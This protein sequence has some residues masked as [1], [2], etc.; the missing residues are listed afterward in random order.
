MADQLT[1]MNSAAAVSPPN[2]SKERAIAFVTETAGLANIEPKSCVTQRVEP[3]DQPLELHLRLWPESRTTVSQISNV[4]ATSD[5]ESRAATSRYLEQEAQHVF[6]HLASAKH[7]EGLIAQN[8]TNCYVDFADGAALAVN[9]V[10]ARWRE[11]CTQCGATGKVRCH[12]GQ[13]MYGRCSVTCSSCSGNGKLKCHSCTGG[14]VTIYVSVQRSDGSWGQESRWENC[15]NCGGTTWSQSCGACSGSGHVSCPSCGGSGT[16]TCSGCSGHKYQYFEMVTR[17]VMCLKREVIP[18][19]DAPKR[20]VDALRTLAPTYV[21]RQSAVE[22]AL[23]ARER[24]EVRRRFSVIIKSLSFDVLLGGLPFGFEAIG[25]DQR[26]ANSP[27]FMDTL[28][29]PRM[30]DIE[31]A[32]EQRRYGHALSAIKGMP[33]LSNALHDIAR[34]EVDNDA[35]L[36]FFQGGLTKFC[37]E[38]INKLVETTYHSIGQQASKQLWRSSFIGIFLLA[39][40]P[41]LLGLDQFVMPII[42]PQTRLLSQGLMRFSLFCL[43][44]AVP[45]LILMSFTVAKA[46]RVGAKAVA[47]A[48]GVP[49]IRLSVRQRESIGRALVITA[50]GI[51]TAIGVRTTADHN[52]V[53]FWIPKNYERNLSIWTGQVLGQPFFDDDMQN[54]WRQDFYCYYDLYQNHIT[55]GP[56]TQPP[57]DMHAALNALIESQKHQDAEKRAAINALVE[58]RKQQAQVDRTTFT[59]RAGIIAG[60]PAL[61]PNGLPSWLPSLAAPFGTPVGDPNTY[62][63]QY[64]LQEL[65]VL[66]GPLTGTMTPYTVSAFD[67][68]IDNADQAQVHQYRHSQIS[69]GQAAFIA[70]EFADDQIHI[71][72]PRGANPV[73]EFPNVIRLALG[74]QGV[75]AISTAL[76]QADAHL[77]KVVVWNTPSGAVQGRVLASQDTE[78][79]ARGCMIADIEVDTRGMAYRSSPREL[80]HSRAGWEVHG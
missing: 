46:K 66:G 53:D 24:H 76:D 22:N 25:K 18:Y 77:G 27:P 26:L 34:R 39:F 62:E 7:L 28:T 68:L 16:L 1:N 70:Q 65:G 10:S 21:F 23:T 78:N 30:I 40:L 60:A 4:W 43:L 67:Y 44:T 72:L 37:Q 13:N 49:G 50:V 79:Q 15:R 47:A 20:F 29:A 55:S 69:M 45:A 57:A 61:P 35:T 9:P 14:R 54:C 38:R 19:K 42:G 41:T 63:M 6:E 80:C 52:A 74:T 51:G 56:N 17:F 64:L 32:L 8:P 73:A 2:H 12:S 5:F 58:S 59:P 75:N 71:E 31:G 33:L 3:S 48:T 36:H 11:S